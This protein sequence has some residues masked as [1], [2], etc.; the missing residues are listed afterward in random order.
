M[1]FFFQ[2]DNRGRCRCNHFC[3]D[4]HFVGY[5]DRVRELLNSGIP[6]KKSV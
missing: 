1:L 4:N 6:V 5:S 3:E 2:R